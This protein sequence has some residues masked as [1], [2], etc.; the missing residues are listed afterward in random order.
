MPDGLTLFCW[1]YRIEGSWFEYFGNS[2]EYLRVA[3]AFEFLLELNSWLGTS[4][5]GNAWVKEYKPNV[6]FGY[7][8]D[9]AG[10]DFNSIVPLAEKIYDALQISANEQLLVCI[11]VEKMLLDVRLKLVPQDRTLLL[12]AYL[13]YVTISQSRAAHRMGRFPFRV[14]WG[15]KIGI[16]LKTYRE[17]KEKGSIPPQL[18]FLPQSY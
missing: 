12:A 15:A 9:I 8:A 10:A 14:D 18:P 2:E 7:Y 1:R 13:D 16:L 3:S 17:M 11:M 6:E 4:P 5:E